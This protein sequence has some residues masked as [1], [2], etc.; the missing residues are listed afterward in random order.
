MEEEGWPGSAVIQAR[1]GT[2]HLCQAQETLEMWGT[3]QS[4]GGFEKGGSRVGGLETKGGRAF[5]ER[6]GAQA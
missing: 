5:E 2:P 6:V 4:R 3:A 1:L